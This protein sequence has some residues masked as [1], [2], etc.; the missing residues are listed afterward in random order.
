MTKS[1]TRREP[2][3]QELRD[4][5]HYYVS[6]GLPIHPVGF[7]KRPLTR[8]GFKDAT[9]DHAQVD[10][11]VDELRQP[12]QWAIVCGEPSGVVVTD[13]DLRP[14]KVWGLDSL[15]AL[16]ICSRTAT[17]PTAH[18][19][20]GGYHQLFRYPG[21][22]VKSDVGRLPDGRSAPGIDIR[23]DGS[24]AI[25]PPGPGRFWDP[26]LGPD[27]KLAPLPIWAMPSS[28]PDASAAP[29]AP[30]APVGKL[31]AY[32]EKVLRS[33]RR[34]ILEA[35]PG[36]RHS[37]VLRV[38]YSIAGFVDGFGLP[39]GLA[40]DEMERAALKQPRSRPRPSTKEIA[41]TVRDAFAAGLRKQRRPR[42]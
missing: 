39:A 2:D 32:G 31:S 18:T 23:G 14:G 1:N 13:V 17:T 9:L 34:E 7:D 29:A 40:L 35:P 30:I 8:H 12:F 21:F 28:A 41:K 38:V 22:P 37:T 33:A 10:R 36:Q 26:H 42:Q 6:R 20:S 25:V 27:L 15:E 24:S 11:W 4:W 5:G 16:G 19:P 3:R